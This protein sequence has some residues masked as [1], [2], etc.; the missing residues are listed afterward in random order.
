LIE[1]SAPAA[2]ALLD[3]T[4]WLADRQPEEDL[5]QEPILYVT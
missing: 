3:L 1:P 2:R 5:I 4:D